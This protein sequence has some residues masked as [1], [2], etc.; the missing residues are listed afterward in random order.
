MLNIRKFLTGIRIIAKSVLASDTQGEIEV[1]SISGKLNYHNGTT[2]SPMLTESHTAAVTNKSIDADNNTITNI[3]NADIKSGAAIARNKLASGT[4]SVVPV[5]DGSGVL[6][7]STV[8]TTELNKLSGISG[9]VTTDSNTQ[10][11]TNKTFDADGTGNSISNIEN[12]DI[13]SG[14]NIA[15]N[16]LASGTASVVPV[17]DGTGVLIDSSVTTTELNKLSGL[18]GNITTDTNTQTL[19]NKTLT[20]PVIDVITLDGQASTPANPSAGFF[21]AYVKDSTNKLTLLDSAGNELP[22]GSGGGSLN[23]ISNGDAEAGTTGWAVYSDAPGAIPVNG[24]G[25]SANVTI[26]TSSTNPL[27][28][29]NSFILTKDAADRQGQGFSYDFTIN[30]ESK[31]KVLQVSMS[32]LVNSGTFVA[33]TSSANSDI[34]VYLYDITNSVLIEPSSI[35]LLSNSTTIADQFNATFQTASNSTSYRLILHC[36]TTSA[37]AYSLKVDSIVV[38]PSTYVYGTPITDWQTYV[39]SIIGHVSNP[40]KGTTITDRAFWRRVGDSIHI[41]YE[42]DQSSAGS[43]G[44]G[45]YKYSLPPGI[46]IDTTKLIAANASGSTSLGV[47]TV[48]AG[49]NVDYGVVQASDVVGYFSIA[50]G[51]T[52]SRTSDTL[53]SLSN[54]VI[55]TSAEFMAP[56]LGWSS[57]VQTSDQTDTRIVAASYNRGSALS[58]PQA[59]ATVLPFTTIEYDTHGAYNTTS[60]VYTVPVSGKYVINAFSEF[61]T[62][63][64]GHRELYVRKNISTIKQLSYAGSLS[65]TVPTM[66]NGSATF[67]CNIG[68]TLEICVYQD[69]GASL[70]VSGSGTNFNFFSVERISGPSAIA[71]NETIACLYKGASGTLNGS[72]NLITYTTKVADTHSAYN[73]GIFTAPA[74]G[75]YDVSARISVSGTTSTGTY[76]QIFIFINGVS[77]YAAADPGNAGAG[78]VYLDVDINSIPLKAGDTISF[79]SNTGITSP[80]F[81]GGASLNYFSI[82]RRGI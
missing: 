4:A 35:K 8:T 68:D 65:G 3:D 51:P 16:K 6:I 22:I 49:I 1:D 37:A 75:F 20:A 81:G 78:N 48:Y 10:T 77:T 17:N 36:S 60:G 66:M 26:T 46:N 38:S 21:K 40:T 54:S 33:G 80:T 69:S 52:A 82:A 58:I 74:S 55:Q 11:F 5:N 79:Y 25:G 18:S 76:T 30:N 7:D 24:T 62:N 13:K 50:S 70:N 28:G 29:T 15:R 59:T 39:P 41:R 43:A 47:A 44:S 14:A 23:F 67:D 53:Y 12:A 64:T 72:D 73:S 31:A 34:I 19:T 61:A 27:A 56:I 32:Y 63:G 71:A 9:N 45:Y 2:R 42:Y 57:S